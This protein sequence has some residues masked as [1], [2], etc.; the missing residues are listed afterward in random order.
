V[1]AASATTQPAYENPLMPNAKLRQMYS[2]MLRLRM[3]AGRLG[4]QQKRSA[5][6]STNGFEACLVSPTLDLT[7]EDLVLDA[8]QTP[9]IDFLRGKPVEQV[10]NPTRRSGSTRTL[11]NCGA[12]TCVTVPA[13]GPERL[14]AAVGA[15]AAL[16]ANALRT[17]AKD[18]AVLVCYMRP[19]D[20][21]PAAWTKALTFVSTHKLPLLFV[22]LRTSKPQGSRTGQ[23]AALALRSRIPGIPVDQDDAVAL[24]RTS[25]EAI[26]H[27]RIGGGGAL[28]EC[29]RY[30]VE[31]TK[32]TRSDAITGLANYML[33]RHVADKRW[34]ES[35]AKSFARRIGLQL[36]G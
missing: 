34:M 3:L 15:A 31:G 33:P 35:E 4:P 6:S 5:S 16:K 30:V 36:P 19:E 8:F 13:S 22:V 17:G 9:A 26:G 32:P 23:M 14:W 28:I 25:Q 7:S 18:G 2:A 11:A 12:A 24:Y 27:A 29:V 10:L 20:A 1:T 21:P